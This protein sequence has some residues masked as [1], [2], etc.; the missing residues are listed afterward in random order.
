MTGDAAAGD[1]API[2]PD[3]GHRVPR[4]HRVDDALCSGPAPAGHCPF[5][6][7]ACTSDDQCTTGANGRCNRVPGGLEA[8]TCSYDTCAS[9][10]ACPA[11][12]A[13]ACH[14]AELHPTDNQCV[15][16]NCRVDSEC[17]V[18]GF[19][20]P[21]IG[22]CE[23]LVGYYCHTTNDECVDDVDCPATPQGSQICAYD[24]GHAR[25]Q[26]VQATRCE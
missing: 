14:G 23:H 9:D 22:P 7:T 11:H 20:S 8:C 12:H 26:C 6:G 25:W 17:G 1:D 21:S 15:D 2:A 16:G 19:C 13:C 24:T 18:E 5:T 3:A 4:Y 10:A